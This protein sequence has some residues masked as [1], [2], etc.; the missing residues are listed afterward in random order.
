M[1]SNKL[2]S[3]LELYLRNTST[4][5]SESAIYKY[6]IDSETKIVQLITDIIDDTADVTDSTKESEIQAHQLLALSNMYQHVKKYGIDRTFLSLYNDNHELDKFCEMR[7]PSYESF[8]TI[9]NRNSK[10][11]VAF[12]VAMED[13][14]DEKKSWWRHIWEWITGIWNYITG[15]IAS[16]WNKILQFFG[17]R[18]KDLEKLIDKLTDEYDVSMVLWPRKNEKIALMADANNQYFDNIINAETEIVTVGD[19]TLLQIDEAIKDVS[20]VLNSNSKDTSK[21]DAAKKKLNDAD[22]NFTKAANKTIAVPAIK[23]DVKILLMNLFKKISS[24]YKNA[25]DVLTKQDKLKEN[26]VSAVKQIKEFEHKFNKAEQNENV[27]K[28][29]VG[30]IAIKCTSMAKKISSTVV[31]HGK[32]TIVLINSIYK[33]LRRIGNQLRD[34]DDCLEFGDPDDRSKTVKV[35]SA[36]EMRTRYGK[37]RVTDLSNWIGIDVYAIPAK[38]LNHHNA[39]ARHG[40]DLASSFIVLNPDTVVKARRNQNMMLMLIAQLYHE[41]S[42]IVKTGAT[43][44]YNAKK[45]GPAHMHKIPISSEAMAD[46]GSAQ[47]G[48]A[49]A[50]IM[51]LEK[52]LK[53]H[54]ENNRADGDLPARIELIKRWI[55]AHPNDLGKI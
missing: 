24:F 7:F 33:E 1:R 29:N 25:K 40:R 30:E 44:V 18:A 3:G 39:F 55:D 16:L 48:W 35:L 20:A 51:A 22:T 31:K 28:S 19:E 53:A 37:Y 27:T 49:K 5:A 13:G 17:L 47:R 15:K 42:H 43:G 4:T 23:T 32:D 46:R 38:R 50:M 2:F 26:A 12:I 6:N 45:N 10:Y 41:V 11:S 54:R 8:S 34:N 9:G 21:L 52:S 36:Q 14:T